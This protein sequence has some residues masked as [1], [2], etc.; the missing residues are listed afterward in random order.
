ML[1]LQ[2]VGL[3]RL[4]YSMGR[5]SWAATWFMNWLLSGEL[6]GGD[7]QAVAQALEPRQGFVQLV[8]NETA[9]RRVA[10]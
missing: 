2:T 5:C 8:T 4:M 7:R 6:S 1:K 10:D 3:R 9:R